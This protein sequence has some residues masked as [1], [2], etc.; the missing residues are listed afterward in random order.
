MAWGAA[1]LLWLLPA[2]AMQFTDEAISTG[3]GSALLQQSSQPTIETTTRTG[4]RPLLDPYGP[5]RTIET[6]AMG[7]AGGNWTS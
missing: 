7:F 5:P 6:A 2:V 4:W 1:A 3:L